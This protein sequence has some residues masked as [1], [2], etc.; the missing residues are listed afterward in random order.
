[1]SD[2]G[3]LKA[4]S[5]WMGLPVGIWALGFVSMLMDISSEMIHAL[6]PVYLTVGLGATALTVGVIEGIAEATAAITK[7]FSGALSDRMGR[8]PLII[9]TSLITGGAIYLLRIA[10]YGWGIGSLMLIL[11]VMMY[12]RM[13]VSESYIIGQTTERHRSM[14]YG[15]YYFSMTETGAILAPVMGKFID[16]YGFAQAFTLAS[17][18]IVAMT[19][20]CAYFLRGSRN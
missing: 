11:G 13:P 2:S 10:P 3:D 15:I 7:V 18:I 8:V 1:M 16:N 5:A 6:L 9:A 17:A 19:L 14:I 12:I 20:A 4:N